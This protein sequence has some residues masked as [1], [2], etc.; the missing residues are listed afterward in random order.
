MKYQI[1][2]ADMFV[3]MLHQELDSLQIKAL[4]VSLVEQGQRLTQFWC[5]SIITDLIW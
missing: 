4:Q 3:P 5:I 2:R 1:C